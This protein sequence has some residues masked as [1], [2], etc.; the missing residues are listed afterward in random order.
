MIRVKLL[1]MWRF[2]FSYSCGHMIVHH[3]V[4]LVLF[5]FE[6]SHTVLQAQPPFFPLMLDI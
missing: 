2:V 6:E 5:N 4:Y 3:S 1:S